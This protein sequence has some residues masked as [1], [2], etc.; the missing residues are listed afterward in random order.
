MALLQSSEVQTAI[1]NLPVDD[2][3]GRTLLD[4]I[5]QSI[6]TGTQIDKTSV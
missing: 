5:K 1:N 2:Y 3:A 4:T 6:D